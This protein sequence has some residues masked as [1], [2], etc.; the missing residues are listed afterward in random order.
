MADPIELEEE[1]EEEECP[2]CPPVGAPAWM[3]TF[4]D[5]ATLLMA[6]FVLIL[7]FAEFNTPKFKQI[8]GSLKNAFGVQ[9]VVPVV[10]QPKGTTVISME[11]SPSPSPSVTQEMTQE[12]TEVQKPEIE[13]DSKKEDSVDGDR[14][15]DFGQSEGSGQPGETEGQK[16]AAEMN[17]AELG[18]ALQDA[19][20]S[21]EV[22][23]E[24]MGEN[25]VI[26][27]PTQDQTEKDLPSLLEETLAALAEARNASG[28]AESEVLFGGLEQQLKELAQVT[29]ADREGAGPSE[30]TIIEA[31]QK[32]AAIQSASLTQDRLSVA[33]ESEIAQGLVTVEQREDSV[34]VT[35]GSGG[36]FPSGSADL[37]REATEILSRVAFASMEGDSEVTVTGHTDDVPI[38][39]GAL[40]RDN[41]DLAAARAASV[42]QSM[43]GTG[44]V[45]PG[46]MK[47]VSLG[48][49]QPIE[50]NSTPEGREKNRRIEIEIS[51]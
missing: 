11:F 46:K 40:F 18:E 35:I 45:A 27:F 6:F 12:T 33:L 36:A 24:M 28:Q 4:A 31:Q 10:E 2:K 44:L 32:Q 30:Q 37:T 8:S 20:A 42:V 26:N 43:Q 13:V 50:D 14:D 25:V 1:Q 38:S 23:V 48:E 7:S 41:W 3:A 39:D 47:A 29:S 17:A 16:T 19:I 15:D 34:F 51:Y 22:S 5:M 9:K 21:G 49:T